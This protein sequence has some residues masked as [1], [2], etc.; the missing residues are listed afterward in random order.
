MGDG[1]WWIILAMVWKHLLG[2]GGGAG[3]DWELL[4][5]LV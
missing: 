4:F 5:S 3:L 2:C 1:D